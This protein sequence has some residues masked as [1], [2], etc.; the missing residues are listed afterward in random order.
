MRPPYVK[1]QFNCWRFSRPQRRAFH[2]APD[3]PLCLLRTV[4]ETLMNDKCLL[5]DH[6]TAGILARGNMNAETSSSLIKRYASFTFQE[7]YD[8]KIYL[9]IISQ[10][11]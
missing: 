8:G 7:N 9:K 11:R 10:I 5:F 6:V 3:A 4:G 1:A 2:P